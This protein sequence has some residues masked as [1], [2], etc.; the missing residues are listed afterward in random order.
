MGVGDV[1]AVADIEAATGSSWGA[2]QV[3]SE[4]Q[5]RTGVALVAVTSSG[6]VVAWCC[7]FQTGSDAELLKITV[8]PMVQ[9]MGLGTALLQTLFSLFTKKNVE[10]IFLEVRSRNRPALNLYE[11]HNFK[12]IGRRNNYYKEPTDDAVVCVH[13]LKTNDNE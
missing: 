6:E 10:Q 11:K 9:R 13:R 12:E 2:D 7:A 8:S 1:S 5:R 4:L 3:A